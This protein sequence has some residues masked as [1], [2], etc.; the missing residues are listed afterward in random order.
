M[1]QTLYKENEAL[2]ELYRKLEEAEAENASNA[3]T[4]SHDDLMEKLRAKF[5]IKNL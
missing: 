5:K 2:N 3:P 4:I 1:D